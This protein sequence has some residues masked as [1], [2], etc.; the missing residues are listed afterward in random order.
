MENSSEHD[1]IKPD[2]STPPVDTEG[3]DKV[4][5][6]MN[7]WPVE[8][9]EHAKRRMAETGFSHLVRESDTHDTSTDHEQSD[10]DIPESVALF[11][12]FLDKIETDKVMR[13]GRNGAAKY[14]KVDQ[15]KNGQLSIITWDEGGTD[16]EYDDSSYGG[17]QELK[18]IVLDDNVLKE[19]SLK[20]DEK[21]FNSGGIA[22]RFRLSALMSE[23]LLHVDSRQEIELLVEEAL[24]RPVS[25]YRASPLAVG[26]AGRAFRHVPPDAREAIC[27]KVQ[28][29]MEHNPD[30][31]LVHEAVRR[32]NKTAHTSFM[33][34][35]SDAVE[36]W[37]ALASHD[38]IKPSVFA[39]ISS[40]REP[41]VAAEMAALSVDQDV[42]KDIP[43]NLRLNFTSQYLHG[44]LTKLSELPERHQTNA[45]RVK[46]LLYGK[47]GPNRVMPLN[48]LIRLANGITE[49]IN[50]TLEADRKLEPLDMSGKTSELLQCGQAVFRILD[51]TGHDEVAIEQNRAYA[52]LF[53]AIMKP[54]YERFEKTRSIT[55][56]DVC[57][58]YPDA[59]ND[60]VLDLQGVASTDGWS[61]AT[62]HYKEA[63]GVLST[64]GQKR[65]ARRKH[66]AGYGV[67]S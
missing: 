15:N 41:R 54:L 30:N 52:E 47:S 38:L 31:P 9:R 26:I 1:N 12:A 61:A 62:E 42:F 63:R 23:F 35:Q 55:I 10:K 18:R 16:R 34:N 45:K 21:N 39:D 29:N 17:R 67:V 25:E 7:E 60:L 57:A 56:A 66:Q 64:R 5:G 19:E 2:K 36:L 24:T 46:E 4:A 53:D 48:D 13:V 22:S 27:N 8:L 3:W 40:L 11:R 58:R 20:E 59:Q 65:L 51:I 28:E 14:F 37:E 49:Q 44:V 33:H 43:Q 32:M 6:Q 50:T